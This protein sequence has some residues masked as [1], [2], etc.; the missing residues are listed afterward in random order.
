MTAS[1][2]EPS[3]SEDT[4]GNVNSFS[5]KSVQPASERTSESQEIIKLL[6]SE[7]KERERIENQLR[8]SENKFRNIIDASPMGIHMYELADDGRLIFTGANPAADRILN[9]DNSQFIANLS[10]KPLRKHFRN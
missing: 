10:V 5:G 3:L 9:I 4:L 6:K 2:K 1:E 7:I 8:E